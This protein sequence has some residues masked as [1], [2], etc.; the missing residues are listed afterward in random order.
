MYCMYPGIRFVCFWRKHIQTDKTNPT[1][2]KGKHEGRG[3]ASVLMWWKTQDKYF[4]NLSFP[5]PDTEPDMLF[6]VLIDSV[7]I[8]AHSLL[9][10]YCRNQNPGWMFVLMT[11]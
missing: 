8:E 2:R 5:L 9:Q 11:I 4:V 6:Y 10:I 7:C 3:K 1:K